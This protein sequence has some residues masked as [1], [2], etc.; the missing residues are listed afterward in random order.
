ME[1]QIRS[2][3]AQFV[4]TTL[5]ALI[6]FFKCTFWYFAIWN[7]TPGTWNAVLKV[8]PVYSLVL[9]VVWQGKKEHACRKWILLGLLV[10]SVGDVFMVW[11][12]QLVNGMAT[13]A[14]AQICYIKAFGFTPLKPEI[15]VILFA[16]SAGALILLVPGLKHDT[17]LLLG[18]PFYSALL[19]TMA[20]RANARFFAKDRTCKWI[21][22]S[23]AIGS[24]FFLLS[25][26]IIGFDRFFLPIEDAQVYIMSTYYVAQLGIA[27]SAAEP[28][29]KANKQK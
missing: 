22:L 5:I 20:W 11:R 25:D 19:T 15:G 2:G 10:S 23:T 16:G 21:R 29:P 4:R 26:M 24:I 3:P 6:P 28:L 17:F 1:V 18:L 9:F 8:L 12:T 13:F 14:L 7:Q 27:L